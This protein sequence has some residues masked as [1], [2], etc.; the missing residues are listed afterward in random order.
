[1]RQKNS[2]R[3]QRKNELRHD[4]LHTPPGRHII[5]AKEREDSDYLR[6]LSLKVSGVEFGFKR[7]RSPRRRLPRRA[8]TEIIQRLPRTPLRAQRGCMSEVLRRGGG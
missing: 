6:A 2:K 5:K 1:M 8:K 7:T 3:R 4:W